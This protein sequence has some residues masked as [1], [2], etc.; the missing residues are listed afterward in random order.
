MADVNIIRE[1]SKFVNAP[2][3]VYIHWGFQD[4]LFEFNVIGQI[5]EQVMQMIDGDGGEMI[6]SGH[7]LGG[8]TLISCQCILLIITL[9]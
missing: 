9:T 6:V 1:K 4:A 8:S 5:E 3:D 2:D 7:S